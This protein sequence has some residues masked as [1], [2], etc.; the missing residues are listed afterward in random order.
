MLITPS[1]TVINPNQNQRSKMFSISTATYFWCNLTYTQTFKWF[2]NK[3]YSNSSQS[4]DLSSNPS[5]ISSE[6]VIK[7]NTLDYGVYEFIC[8]VNILL[9]DSGKVYT[10]NASTFIQIIPTG[11]VVYTLQ[12]G[13][14]SISIGFEQSLNLSPPKYSFDYDNLAQIKNLT[15]K[16]YCSPINS[17][18][19]DVSKSIDLASLKRNSSL[20]QACFS[21]EGFKL[22]LTFN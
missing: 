4:V 3:I 15:F 6:I 2:L 10:N 20:I 13:I 16:F 11:L 14:Q 7:P 5:S 19:I 12:N 21:S 18:S 17:N 8:Q 9:T 1:F 22:I